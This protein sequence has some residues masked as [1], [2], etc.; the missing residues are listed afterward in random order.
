[1]KVADFFE[2]GYR[3]MA[4]YFGV[5]D[6]ISSEIEMEILENHCISKNTT[7]FSF[8]Q[9]VGG[10][11]MQRVFACRIF[12][13][14]KEYQEVVRRIEG[15]YEI[16]VKNM[17]YARMAGYRTVW[18][19]TKPKFYYFNESYRDK[20]L[21]YSY[22]YFNVFCVNYF[23]NISEIDPSLKYCGLTLPAN[24]SV[25]DFITIYRKEPIIEILAKL[26]RLDLMHNYKLIVKLREDKAFRKWFLKNGPR[27]MSG[28]LTGADLIS[29][30]KKGL[31][32]QEYFKLKGIIQNV[33][34]VIKRHKELK[35]EGLTKYFLDNEKNSDLGPSNYCDLIQALKFFHL[36]L[37]DTKNIYPK[38]FKYWH[39][40][41]MEKMVCSQN[42]ELDENIKKMANR[43][44][45]LACDVGNLKL[46]FPT[47][48]VDFIN[49]GEAL[50]HCVGK[51][52]YNEKMAK[53]TSLI[54]FIRKVEAPDKPYV[55]MEYDAKKKKILQIYGDHDS[56]PE[57]SCLDLINNDW[58]NM[59]KKLRIRGSAA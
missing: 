25:I 41:Y 37:T 33:N 8:L 10:K 9:N 38:D 11:I 24:I 34:Y 51:M 20:W 56:K 45:K 6:K 28:Y 3:Y 57:K 18:P 12:R 27:T 22:D 50:H 42:A 30:Y 58:L 7:Y 32:S 21:A 17:Y 5:D 4:D 15:S 44:K 1:M 14:K 31:T 40:F 36:D 26:H 47:K 43:F 48:T 39:D 54:L 52:G 55:T 35:K 46:I 53:G 29:A 23:Q 16:Y 59:A 49:E 2:K 13:R 19:N